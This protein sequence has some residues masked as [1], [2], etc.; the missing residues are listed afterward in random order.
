M[1]GVYMCRSWCTHISG[2][3]NEYCRSG[4]NRCFKLA[5][6]EY[7]CLHYAAACAYNNGPKGVAACC[8]RVGDV[9]VFGDL[10]NLVI[11]ETGVAPATTTKVG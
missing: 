3:I 1:G 9:Y 10:D 11:A 8:G 2:G 7:D 4:E 6:G 5:W